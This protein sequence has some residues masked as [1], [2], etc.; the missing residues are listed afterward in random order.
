MG[1]S[2]T[3]GSVL[4]VFFSASQADIIEGE[5]WYFRANLIASEIGQRYGLDQHVV[6][7]VIAALSP[8]N[9]WSRNVADAEALVKAF[10]LGEVN[11]KAVKVSTFNRNKEKA[12]RILGGESPRDVL[13]GLKVRAF[14]ECIVGGNVVCVDGH[15]Y[16]IWLGQRVATSKTPKIS[17]KLYATIAQDYHL[18]ASQIN[19]ITGKQYTGSQVQAITWVAWR[20]LVN[21]GEA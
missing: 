2:I 19:A 18:A 10:Q 13:G 17:P 12:I 1:I 16:S 20:N 3:H 6:A 7:G 8:N 21:G 14:Y 11:L 15:A 4:A 9:R 5:N